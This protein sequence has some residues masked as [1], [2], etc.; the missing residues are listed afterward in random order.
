MPIDNQPIPGQ[1][2][3]TDTGTPGVRT[4]AA[5]K[6]PKSSDKDIKLQKPSKN[7]KDIIDI[8][9]TMKEATG[10]TA[11]FTFGRMNP[12][13]TGHE[14]LIQKVADVAKQHGAKGHIVLSHS[15]DNKN[16]P[17]PQDKKIGYVQKINKNV[18]VHG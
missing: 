5:L 12:P 11:V 14:K 1:Q 4:P 15:H 16:N 3:G 17:I 6:K 7:L 2:P 10:K 13:T 18:H 8:S 9:P